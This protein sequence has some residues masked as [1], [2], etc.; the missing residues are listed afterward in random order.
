MAERERQFESVRRDFTE[1]EIAR[2]HEQLVVKVGEVRGLR[3]QKGQM[4]ATINNQ[5]RTSEKEVWD[6]QGKLEAGFELEECEIF[7]LMDTPRTGWKTIVRGD[8]NQHLREVPMSP[9]EKQLQLFN[10][11]PGGPPEVSTE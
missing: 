11:L 10:D 7:E 4:V 1:S 5:I 6:L 8:N 2:M 9:R 3:E